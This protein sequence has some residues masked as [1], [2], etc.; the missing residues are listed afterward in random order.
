[1]ETKAYRMI[2]KMIKGFEQKI[3][4][5]RAHPTLKS[6]E[7][8]YLIQKEFYENI[9]NAKEQHKPLAWCGLFV[10]LELLHAMDI[11]P[12]I[13]ESFATVVGEGVEEYMDFGEAQGVPNYSCS[14]H[15]VAMGMTKAGVIPPPDLIISTAQTCDSTVKIFELLSN[16]Y[17]C[18]TFFVDRAYSHDTD[19][20]IVYYKNELESLIDF[21]EEQTQKKLDYERLREHVRLSQI[22][23]DYWY[24]IGEFRKNIPSPLPARDAFRDRGVMLTSA[25][26][27][28]AVRYFEDRYAEVK[29]KVDKKEGGIPEERFRIIWLYAPP[30]FDLKL[31]DWMGIEHKA[32][33]A[34]ETFNALAPRGKEDPSDPLDYLA[35][36]S[37][38]GYLARTSYGDM[39]AGGTVADA[40]K[41]CEDYRADGVVFFAHFNCKQYCGM[42][43]LYADGIREG[44][45]IPTL[46][47]DGDLLDPRV[48]SSAQMKNRLNEFFAML[49]G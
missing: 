4:H 2:D 36:V 11:V 47:V 19:E 23:Y 34:M 18:P 37:Y 48:V 31:M 32:S 27:P 26:L 38:R 14:P 40:V 44:A 49:S 43:R 5:R 8:F 30:F 12:L 24:Q 9:K 10:P 20:A 13:P 7:Y 41:M 17:K 1:M 25:G 3:Q 42:L 33:I 6:M 16:H 39:A 46:T 22:A 45:G 28:E 15:R 29:A 35:R 21:L